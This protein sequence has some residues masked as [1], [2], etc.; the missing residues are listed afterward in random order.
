MSA[1]DTES[2]TLSIEW[3][4][5]YSRWVAMNESGLV[6]AESDELGKFVRAI[7]NRVGDDVVIILSDLAQALMGFANWDT[8]CL[9]K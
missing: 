8:A 6:V 4:N 9:A 7:E 5:K 3:S 2:P 1:Q